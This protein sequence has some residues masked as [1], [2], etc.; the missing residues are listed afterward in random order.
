MSEN[1]HGVHY[2]RHPA[3][4]PAVAVP[5]DL[6]AVESGVAAY[7]EALQLK[8]RPVHLSQGPLTA[9]RWLREQPDWPSDELSRHYQVLASGFPGTDPSHSPHWE[10][11]LKST[12]GI[13]RN[14]V[15]QTIEARFRAD[16]GPNRFEKQDARTEVCLRSCLDCWHYEMILRVLPHAPPQPRPYVELV[17]VLAALFQHGAWRLWVLPQLALLAPQVSLPE[18]RQKAP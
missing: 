18:A 10:Q 9:L 17:S 13:E 2:L 11:A 15:W 5:V 12:C 3:G 6:R 8:S 7:L 4:A 1:A 16:L 14:R